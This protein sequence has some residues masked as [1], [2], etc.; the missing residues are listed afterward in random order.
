MYEKEIK[1]IK[2]DL[3]DLKDYI[4]SFKSVKKKIE[5]N[6]FNLKIE[7]SISGVAEV[8]SY[9][10]LESAKHALKDYLLSNTDNITVNSD[11]LEFKIISSKPGYKIKFHICSSKISKVV[12]DIDEYKYTKENDYYWVEEDSFDDWY[13]DNAKEAKEKYD[14][15]VKEYPEK[16]TILVLV[17]YNSKGYQ[18]EN[19][20]TLEKYFDVELF[21]NKY[22]NGKILTEK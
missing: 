17:A 4:I 18:E 3:K 15:I 22:Q 2:D 10:S 16:E 12:S 8:K 7:E 1:L 5:K 6:K 19:A 9:F 14:S 11:D 13:F 20:I 21:V